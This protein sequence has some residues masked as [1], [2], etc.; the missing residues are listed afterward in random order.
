MFLQLDATGLMYIATQISSGMNFLE[1][2]SFIHRDLAA[3][4]CLVGANLLVK[5]ADFGTLVDAC[6]WLPWFHLL[7]VRV[8]AVVEGRHHVHGA[9]RRQVPYQG[10]L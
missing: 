5:V 4:N 8:V 6:F 1:E 2:H 10:F 7:P 9:C 3:R